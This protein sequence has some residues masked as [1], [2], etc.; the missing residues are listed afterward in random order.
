MLIKETIKTKM[1]FMVTV[2][3]RLIVLLSIAVV[4]SP[5]IALA[6]NKGSQNA[7]R[8]ANANT[9]TLLSSNMLPF[10][11][12]DNDKPVGF[13]V[14]I[15]REIMHRLGRTDTIEFD[16]WENAYE[17]SLTEPNTVLWPPSRTPEREAL[18]KWVGPLI[19]EKIILFARKDSGLVI[20]SLED[21]KKV[22]GIATV[23]GFASEKLLQR[24]GFNNL[25]SQRSPLQ[26][27]DALKFGR[28]D[29][30]LNSNITMEQMALSANVDPNMFEPLF[31]VKEIPSYL[32]FSKSVSDE[33]VNQWQATLDEMKQ[34]GA[35]ERIVTNWVPSELLK[36]GDGAV[37]FTEK[38][39]QW[40]E[41]HPVIKVVDYFHEPPFT[42]DLS[43]ANTGY[44][45]DL[46]FATLRKAGLNAEF[47]EGFTSYDSMVNALQNGEVDLLSTMNSTRQLPDSVAKTVPVVR[48][49]N[50]LVAKISTP[51]I[52]QVAD[53]FGKKV[54][55]VKGYAQDQQLDKFPEIERVYVRNNKDGFEA[56][57]I[58]QAEYFLNNHANSTYVLQKTFAT[59]LRIAG[60]LS[61]ADFPPLILS[62]A[63]HTKN[64][65][66]PGIIDKALAAVPINTLSRLRE[67][68]L[69]DEFK[70]VDPGRISL[71]PEEQAFLETHPVI[72]VHNEQ[73]W[74]PF[75]FCEHGEAT[76]FSIDYMNLLADKI[77]LQIEYVSGPS[78]NEFITMTRE[79]QLDV[80]LNIVKTDE[81]E[82]F[83]RFTEKPYIET[84]RAMVVRKDDQNVRNFKDLYGRTVAV[85][86][87]FFYEKYLKKNHPEINVITVKDTAETLRAVVNGDADATLGV[88]AVEQFLIKSHFFSNLKMVVDPREKAL[89]SFPQFIGVRSDWPLLASMLDKAMG[90]VT[91]KERVVL[92]QKWIVQEDD[93]G[94]I[95]LSPDEEAFLKGRPVLRV[96]FDVDWPPV[97]FS[98]KNIGMKGMAADYLSRISELLGIKFEPSQPRS[99]PEMLKAVE[100]GELDFFSAVS[101]TPQR[102]EWLGFTDSYLS[103]PIVILTSKEVPYIGSMLDLEDKPVAVVAGYASQEF[104]LKNH[105][106]LTLLPVRDV[107]E[108]LMTVSTGKAYAFVGSLATASHVM[109]R[110]GL[111]DLKVS[112]ET[113]YSYNLSMGVRKEDTVLLNILDKALAAISPKERNVINSRWTSVTYEHAI[114]YSLLWRIVVAAL[115]VVA[116]VLY[117]NGRLK[118]EIS[119]RKRAE[120]AAETANQAKSDFLANMSHELRTPL[121][122]ILGFAQIMERNPNISSEKEN[123][124]IIQRSGNHL[125]T[126]INQVLD[127]SKIEAG[128]I[129][130]EQHNFD[131]SHMLDDLESMLSFKADKQHL[132]LQFDCA[133]E[134]P[135]FIRTDEVKLRQVLINLLTNAIKFTREGSIVLR[136]SL[137][138]HDD[139]EKVGQNHESLSSPDN[140]V[141]QFE[142]KDTGSGIAPEEM[143]VLFEAFKQ[144][145]SGRGT[146]EGTGLGL[147]ISHKF[148]QLMGGDMHVTSEVG[149]GTTFSFYIQAQV[150]D[151]TNLTAELPTNRAIAIKPGQPRFRMLI[152]DDKQDNRQLLN[153]LLSP[154]GFDL[155]EAAN[156]QEAI[157]ILK[158]WKPHLIWMDMRMPVMDGYEAT[159]LIRA[160]GTAIAQPT[161]IAVTASVFDENRAAVMAIGCDD[162]VIKPFQEKAIVEILH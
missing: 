19:P 25:T 161:I 64:S 55:V 124:R 95:E 123:L 68:W 147:L 56:V 52:T 40:I 152:V 38:E 5:S 13:T 15:L 70:V 10:G 45:Y 112:G 119:E 72:R 159:K 92:S 158:S 65:E 6:E 141:I 125:L 126:L 14:D 84:P 150:A 153:K 148:V 7:A 22:N 67:K 58:G 43:D 110:E 97:E 66:L 2:L 51:E 29:L 50:A 77:G 59:D 60:T 26:G 115:I 1:D 90:A 8:S 32:A 93:V 74:A 31:V 79:R 24:E 146:Q 154:F 41:A 89:R 116:L 12:M 103:F 33:V 18:F 94:R 144:T 71:T 156:G 122:A 142:I 47:V 36:V 54:A 81:R 42:L 107:K 87:G 109:S 73:N 132:T 27:P 78:W 105:P 130:F 106:E 39:R 151:A 44:I 34:D 160:L 117:W 100:N 23:T 139:S 162:I 11:A 49:P 96:A 57:R 102:K 88:I 111:T 37:N 120:E 127:L 20:N 114:D 113:P 136:V 48:T 3:A 98:D 69:S 133:P 53:L 86:K 149:Q 145:A 134:V 121:N 62:F 155:L 140:N 46:L 137:R 21:A 91:D 9:L 138:D 82:K 104:L 99:W 76:G 17:R 157:D 28:V 85:E 61:Y 143:G 30:W 101:P 108:G 80:M 135:R 4:V 128:H 63:V 118:R 129:T 83:I 35:W 131:L 75:N 16:D